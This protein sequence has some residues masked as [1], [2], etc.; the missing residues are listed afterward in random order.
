VFKS[1][2]AKIL[3]IVLF[4]K[5]MLIMD[6]HDFLVLNFSRFLALPQTLMAHLQILHF[7]SV[8]HGTPVE[9]HWCR[10][11]L[12]IGSRFVTFHG[13]SLEA[14]TGAVTTS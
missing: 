5:T 2:I 8:R 13:N 11:L 4:L 9:N 7:I 10:P 12:W 6:F 14:R 3:N 1:H